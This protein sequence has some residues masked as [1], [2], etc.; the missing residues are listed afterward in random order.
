MRAGPRLVITGRAKT[1]LSDR[2]D[3]K[4]YVRLA[5]EHDLDQKRAHPELPTKP[6]SICKATQWLAV[7]QCM[8]PWRGH[9]FLGFVLAREQ[10]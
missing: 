1:A 2:D 9:Y 7:D 10:V 4:I 5:I 8:R 3:V 6:R